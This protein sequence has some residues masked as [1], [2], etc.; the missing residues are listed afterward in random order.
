MAASPGGPINKTPPASTLNSHFSNLGPSPNMGV[1]R[2]CAK[3]DVNSIEIFSEAGKARELPEKV[4]L[5]LPV[6]V[7]NAMFLFF[8]CDALFVLLC[9]TKFFDT[10]CEM[11]T[12]IIFNL[13][14]CQS[15]KYNG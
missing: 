9:S 13:V 2:L 4:K 8:Y 12:K 15:L 1:C 3:E 10:L 5:C 6:L 7:S 11:I 14:T